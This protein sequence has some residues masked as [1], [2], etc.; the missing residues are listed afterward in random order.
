MKRTF[1]ILLL[2]A[3]TVQSEAGEA[4][5][6]DKNS[7]LLTLPSMAQRMDWCAAPK[8]AAERL[9]RYEAFWEV[10]HEEDGDDDVQGRAERHCAYRLVELYL[11]A[12]NTS[13]CRWFLKWLEEHDSGF[14]R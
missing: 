8:S 4:T 7:P 10:Y 6:T 13:K 9:A 14:L 3:L 1:C 12:G 11:Q 5:L 2:I